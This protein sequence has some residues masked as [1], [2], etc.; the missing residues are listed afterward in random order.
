V[1]LSFELLLSVKLPN[2]I[3]ARRRKR[4]CPCKNS[5]D[6]SS[7][8][9]FSRSLFYV[10]ERAE[11]QENRHSKAPRRSI[12][13]A[14]LLVFQKRLVVYNSKIVPSCGASG[15]IVPPNAVFA[16]KGVGSA[17][18]TG[19]QSTKYPQSS[20][21][22]G[23]GIDDSGGLLV[24]PSWLSCYFGRTKNHCFV[25]KRQRWYAH[26]VSNRTIVVAET[27]TTKTATSHTVGSTSTWE[28]GVARGVSSRFPAWWLAFLFA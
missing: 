14:S 7:F 27:T 15:I 23:E 21:E 13:P 20:E 4:M 24:V 9:F 18:R 16:V 19:S 8:Y 25:V 22:S 1:I 11:T 6:L 17:Y 5:I 26:C 12:A 10:M 2:R 3:L 28:D